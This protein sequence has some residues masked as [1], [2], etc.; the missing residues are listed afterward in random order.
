[1]STTIIIGIIIIGISFLYAY[2]MYNMHI[3]NKEKEKINYQEKIDHNNYIKKCNIEKYLNMV[4]DWQIG[5]IIYVKFTLIYTDYKLIAFN[6]NGEVS[7]KK[8]YSDDIC[9]INL[10]TTKLDY[11][12]HSLIQRKEKIELERIK[13]ES[14]E[15]QERLTEYRKELIRLTIED[16]SKES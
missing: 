11:Y 9:N 7:L 10:A 1:M 12:N 3:K 14:K 13:K 16:E 8:I 2:Y 4:M 6:S 15:F 5:D